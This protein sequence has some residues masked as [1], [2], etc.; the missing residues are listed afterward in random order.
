[1]SELR[2]ALLAQKLERESVEAE[3]AEAAARAEREAAEAAAEAGGRAARLKREL[4]EAKEVS[5]WAD[6]A[7]QSSHILHASQTDATFSQPIHSTNLA[8]SSLL[9]PALTSQRYSMVGWLASLI[10]TGEA[11]C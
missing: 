6:W 2:A 10:Q 7:L 8:P 11:N 5:G 1:M 4:M 9:N 3:A